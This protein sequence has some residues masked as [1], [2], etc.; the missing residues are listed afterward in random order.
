VLP[1]TDILLVIAGAFVLGGL[2]KGLI[3]GGLPSIVVPIMAVVV[4][5]AYA[6]AVTLIPVAATNIW[7]AFDGKKLTVVF[8]RFWFYLLPLSIG[9]GVGSQILVGL[10]P[11]IA[12]LLIGIVVILLSPIPLISRRLQISP[13]RELTLHPIIGAG[14]GL[15]GGATVIFTPTLIYFAALR[16]DK[17]LYVAVAAVAAICCMV[18]L[19][20]GLGFSE[21]LNGETMRFSTLLLVPTL[22]GYFIG[23]A[24][25]GTVSQ[26]SFQLLLTASLVF[27]GL[28]LV[29]KGL[30]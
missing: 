12:A 25:R 28:G 23:R 30:A 16:L 27:V 15:L 1:Q 4:D 7:Q 14:T 19:Y 3:G 18:P 9:V 6:A 26:R 10:P 13:E 17:D 21:T 2:V 8:R 5:P 22:M 24:L 29:Y 11:E 20:L